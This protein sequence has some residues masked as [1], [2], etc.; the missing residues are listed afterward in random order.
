M[1][2]KCQKCLSNSW[3]VLRTEKKTHGIQRRRECKICGNRVTTV[4]RPLNLP[5]IHEPTATYA[6]QI[7]KNRK[8]TQ[9][10]Y[11]PFGEGE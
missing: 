7:L 8:Y 4:E 2:F 9:K 11:S 6:G 3:S 1:S 10:R 5:A